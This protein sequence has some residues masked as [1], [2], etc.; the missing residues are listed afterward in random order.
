MQL[1]IVLTFLHQF[2][3]ATRPRIHSLGNQNRYH[4]WFHRR[5]AGLS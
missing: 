5:T 2:Y 1:Y 3:Q 4:Q